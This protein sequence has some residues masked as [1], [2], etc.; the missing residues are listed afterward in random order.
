MTVPDTIALGN[1][2]FFKKVMMVFIAP[3]KVLQIRHLC[4]N[5]EMFLA[6]LSGI[7][8]LCCWQSPSL[9]MVNCGSTR[10]AMQDKTCRTLS[11]FSQD[12][13]SLFLFLPIWVNLYKNFISYE[14]IAGFVVFLF[15]FASVN[16]TWSRQFV[17]CLIIDEFER[18]C[19]RNG[20]IGIQ[21]MLRML[22]LTLV[23]WVSHSQDRIEGMI[24]ADV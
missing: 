19:F 12:A 24:E 15:I 1:V 16:L 8:E 11:S 14:G 21:L 3:A 23:A 13:V 22:P 2:Q 10:W 4:R 17:Y 6:V 7:P 18:S 5:S 9:G 20:L